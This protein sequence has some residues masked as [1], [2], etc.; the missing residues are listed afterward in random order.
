MRKAKQQDMIFCLLSLS[1]LHNEGKTF[2]FVGFNGMFLLLGL[3]NMGRK[4]KDIRD[5]F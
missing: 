1:R 2:A 4:T 3:F 5:K